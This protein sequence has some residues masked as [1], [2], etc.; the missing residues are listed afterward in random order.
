MFDSILKLGH[1]EK[2]L[3]G[4][5]C[6]FLGSFIEVRL[7]RLLYIR[8]SNNFFDS[9]V[10]NKA[11]FAPELGCRI[12]LRC[13]LFYNDAMTHSYGITFMLSRVTITHYAPAKVGF[14]CKWLI[15]FSTYNFSRHKC[16]WAVVTS[17]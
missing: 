12:A 2:I 15:L 3:L 11:H 7:Q 10:A 4:D 5:G 9:S 16:L 8:R 14:L 17:E 6:L 13:H 1:E